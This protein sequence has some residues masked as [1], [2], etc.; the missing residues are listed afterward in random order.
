MLANAMLADS[1]LKHVK[2]NIFAV[3]PV[4]GLLNFQGEKVTLGSNVEEYVGFYARDERSKG[5]SCVI[6]TTHASTKVHLY[7]MAGRHATLV[8]N[9]AADGSDGPKVLPEPGRIV[10]HFAET[11]LTRWGVT[12][13]KKL[14]LSTA[15][16]A[17]FHDSFVKNDAQY[18][19][20]RKKSY[21]VITEETKQQ[22]SVSHGTAGA[23]FTA[24]AG[25]QFQ[26][27]LGLAAGLVVTDSTYKNLR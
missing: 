23:H 24:V 18:V 1:Q 11:C 6:P 5:F 14:N 25:S 12:L 8:G 16:I 2:V 9:A 3:D 4:P 15:E 7:P 26:P 21:T 20:M 22:R 27:E 10:R 17:K 13:N 19:A